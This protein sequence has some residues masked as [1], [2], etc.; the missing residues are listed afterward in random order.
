VTVGCKRAELTNH[1]LAGVWQ[2]EG[3][4]NSGSQNAG[5]PETLT[6]NSSGTFTAVSLSPEFVKLDN[7]SSGQPLSG[8]GTWSIKRRD[9]ATRVYLKFSSFD[10][11]RGPELP[12]GTDS[13]FVEGQGPGL[14][15]F[16]YEGDPDEDQITFFR[17][18][19]ASP[20]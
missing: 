1:P 7:V 17:R 4:S 11:D 6:L 5:A 2:V 13:L 16:Y 8:A 18:V 20:E 10:G 3:K 19:A 15:L 14:R 9:G 12:Y